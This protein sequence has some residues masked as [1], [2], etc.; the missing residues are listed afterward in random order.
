MEM[1]DLKE[2]VKYLPRTKDELIRIDYDEVLFETKLHW[3]LNAG[4]NGK[5]IWFPKNLCSLGAD[6]KQ[7]VLVPEWMARQK[8]YELPR[9]KGYELHASL[10]WERRNLQKWGEMNAPTPKFKIGDIVRVR[11]YDEFTD[12]SCIEY[13]YWTSLYSTDLII[14]DVI[15]MGQEHYYKFENARYTWKEY[16][17]KLSFLPEELFEL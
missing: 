6:D 9:Q 2:K 1:S 15:T 16:F 7:Y 4:E 17:L 10:Y 13:Y 3:L 5:E 8:G 14:N 12:H 11:E